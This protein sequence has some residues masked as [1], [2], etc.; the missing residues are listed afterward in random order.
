MPDARAGTPP[1]EP[2]ESPA[3]IATRVFVDH[4]ELLFSI[5]YNMLGSV[6]DTEDVLQ[7]IW[8]AWV[9]RW[10]APAAEQIAS[11]RA[12]LVRIAVNRAM[13]HLAGISRRRED[14]A[15]PW[16]P[17][18]IITE[19]QAADSADTVVGTESVSLA[20]LVVLET[21]APLERAVFV[22]H[23][24]F[25]Y[26]YTEIA[27]ILDRSPAAIRQLG[28]RAREHVQA[29]RPRYQVDPHVSQQVTE[30]FLAA[31]AGGD[32]NALMHV[33]APDVT[34]WADGGGKAR[35]TGAHPV[36]GRDKI[37]RLIISDAFR[38]PIP[39]LAIRYRRVNGEPS[40]LLMSGSTPY[41]LVF[42]DL[43]PGGDQVRGIYVVSNPEKIAHLG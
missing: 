15:G 12:Y 27:G 38:H 11:P 33:L 34:V 25:G 28:H 26:P 17:E 39:D 7:E 18:P 20:V 35:A 24:V 22:L 4:R 13:A 10:Q 43:V 3:E 40:A 32:L 21:L 19:D 31:V 2:G 37:A 42:L 29:R 41:M 8:L 6:A 23:E 30:R 36:H 1:A 5:V 16:L 9:P 14:Y